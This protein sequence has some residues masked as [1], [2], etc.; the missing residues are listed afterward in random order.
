MCLCGKTGVDGGDSYLRRVGVNYTDTSVYDDGSHELRVK[1]LKW[2]SN[3]DKDMNRLATTVYKTI[4]EMDTSHIQ[5][6]ID[7]DWCKSKYYYDIFVEELKRRNNDSN[8]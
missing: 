6:I 1:Y 8:T 2:G 7:G 4:E 3:Y 5:A